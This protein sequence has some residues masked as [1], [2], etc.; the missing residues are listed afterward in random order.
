MKADAP[1]SPNS[2]DLASAVVAEHKVRGYEA[3]IARNLKFVNCLHYLQDAAEIH[4][5]RIGVGLS[6]LRDKG[7]LWVLSGY[8]IRLDRY[9]M[10]GDSVRVATWPSGW[11]RLFAL[12]EF[13]F[14]DAEDRAYGAATSAW[15][16][17]RADDHHPVRPR[18]H[19]PD[20][21]IRPRRVLE[22]PFG[23][24]P[25]LDHSDHSASF[26][27]RLHDLD[28][29][30]HVNNA[31]YVEWAL[32]AVP[33]ETW[34]RFRPVEVEVRFSAMAFSGDTVEA[35]VERI[36]TESGPAFRHRIRRSSDGTELAR[37]RSRWNTLP[38][39]A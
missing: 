16:L 38:R 7:F 21:A 37:L 35:D 15:L 2:Y 8:H 5:D 22:D 10:I 6:W 33:P 23:R 18:E 32:E 26:R 3:G 25:P 14:L 12:R 29:N 27:V 13:V 17:I 30:R 20:I 24:L 9:P 28:V 4:A 11:H 19:L 36:P 39:R 34:D 1:Y 31:V